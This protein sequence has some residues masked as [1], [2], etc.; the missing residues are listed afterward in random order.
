M[1]KNRPEGDVEEGVR[2]IEW[3]RAHMK[4]LE[5]AEEELVRGGQLR[6]L[7]ISMAMH[8]EAKTG[9]LAIALQK[10][11]AK[12]RLAG[13]NP[14]STDNDVA[15]T[16]ESRYGVETHARKGEAEEEYYENL[17]RVLDIN[18]HLIIDDGADLIS[19]V[20]TER[21][22]MLEDIIG[23]NEE[24]TTG[25][26]RL[27]A[28][29]SD[30]KLEFPVLAVNDSKMKYL[31]DNRYGTGQSTL[32]GF[33][34]A[35][36]L[37][38]AGRNAVVAGY[39]WCGRGIASR[40]KGMGAIVSV[41]EVDPIKAVEARMDGFRVGRMRD[42][43]GDADLVITATGCRDVVTYED[44]L[45]AKDGCMLANAGHFNLEVDVENLRKKAKSRLVRRYV[46]EFRL[47]NGKKLY[48]LADGRLLNLVSGQG[49]PVEIM[50]MSFTVQALGAEYMAVRGKE[51][52]PGV[53]TVPQEID[54]R[55]ARMKLKVE[56]IKI[57]R[58]TAEQ[59]AY[60]SEWKE[61]T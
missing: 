5:S 1:Q 52:D 8:V 40:L 56:G 53:Y 15:L 49:H 20:H 38:L 41:T 57:D 31:F 61:G 22:E 14:L 24:T 44:M 60:L 54:V 16:L 42:M 9:C 3:A 34:N 45:R 19:L 48:L 23:A 35:T 25:V 59:K 32:D 58:L 55:I 4:L 29:H 11:G 46:E 13:C 47:E 28:M 36:N 12:V 7:R 51:M 50:D 30:G 2:K 26:N 33:M 21:R 37:L 27:R 18:P 43:I 10:A 17:N 39:G 6:G